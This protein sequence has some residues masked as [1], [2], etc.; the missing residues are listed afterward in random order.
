M[1]LAFALGLFQRAR[2]G[3]RTRLRR[4]GV[5]GHVGLVQVI[6]DVLLV[7]ARGAVAALAFDLALALGAGLE[8][9]AAGALLL[10]I[11]IALGLLLQ[12]AGRVLGFVGHVVL[13][14]NGGRAKMRPLPVQLMAGHQRGAVVCGGS[15]VSAQ[16]YAGITGRV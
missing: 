8:V 6:L 4:L 7:V 1:R 14:V 2:L 12:A 15:V 13:L 10:R 3:F 9:G 16:P 11:R 5:G